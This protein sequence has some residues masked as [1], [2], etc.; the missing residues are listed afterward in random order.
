[1]PA[2]YI[3][4]RRLARPLPGGEPAYAPATV[5]MARSSSRVAAAD[6]WSPIAT[7][8]RRVAPERPRGWS[9]RL[10]GDVARKWRKNHIAAVST[11]EKL[12]NDLE[13]HIYPVFEK[14][15]IGAVARS[16]IQAWVKGRSLELSPSTVEVIY[17]YVS[18]IFRSA[19]DD[20]CITKSPC[21]NIKLPAIVRPPV[22]PLTTDQVGAVIDALPARFK[23]LALVSAGAGLRPGEARGLTVPWFNFLKRSTRA[24]PPRRRRRPGQAPPPAP[25][26]LSAAAPAAGMTPSSPW[27]RADA[28]RISNRAARRPSLPRSASTSGVPRRWA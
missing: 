26:A 2:P 22:V 1:M 16:D 15:P 13:K 27:A 6:P 9:C 11:L 25:P 7:S 8:A 12:D 24:R 17:R 3:A 5:A 18:A 23:G 10:F 28:T 14:K 20:G 4:P 19:V 21:V